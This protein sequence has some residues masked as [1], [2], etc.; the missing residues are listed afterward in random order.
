MIKCLNKSFSAQET[1]AKH[2]MHLREK[3]IQ[4][5]NTTQIGHLSTEG[6]L[7]KRL[8]KNTKS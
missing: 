1:Y 2:I 6:K 3:N 7:E 4:N 8:G 5:P